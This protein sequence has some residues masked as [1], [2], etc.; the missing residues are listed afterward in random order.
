MSVFSAV[1]LAGLKQTNEVRMRTTPQIKSMALRRGSLHRL[2]HCGMV[3]PGARPGVDSFGS[4]IKAL[5]AAA[6][7]SAVALG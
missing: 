2:S 5:R 6:S 3:C 4:A 7:C 1:C